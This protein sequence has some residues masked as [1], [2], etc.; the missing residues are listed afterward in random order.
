M[1]AIVDTCVWSLAFRRR[2]MLPSAELDSLLSLLQN[3]D[4]AMIGAVRQEL[5]TGIRQK[6][7]FDRL[8][9]ALDAFDDLPLVSEDYVLAASMD[10]VCRSH[11]VQGSGIDF[12]ICAVAHRHKLAIFTTDPD[13]KHYSKWVSIRLHKIH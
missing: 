5:L 1:K 8:K 3:D 12:L 13:F 11:G 10:N 2:I 7:Q 6:D 9:A 4:A